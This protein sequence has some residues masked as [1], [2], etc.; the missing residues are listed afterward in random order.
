MEG[1]NKKG[2]GGLALVILVI[3]IIVV[4]MVFKNS[5]D[6]TSPQFSEE[7]EEILPGEDTTVVIESDLEDIDLGDLDAEFES[8]EADLNQL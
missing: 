7:L 4:W 6:G 5:D 3:I 1:K 8:I 2:S